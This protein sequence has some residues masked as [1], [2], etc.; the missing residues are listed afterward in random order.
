MY[1]M[2]RLPERLLLSPGISVA[3]G[4][5]FTILMDL[6]HILEVLVEVA[7][8]VL[9]LGRWSAGNFGVGNVEGILQITGRVL[10]RDEEGIEVLRG[11]VSRCSVKMAPRAR[12]RSL[13]YPEA[14]LDVLVGGHLD[15]ASLEEDLSRDS[16]SQRRAVITK[17]RLPLLVSPL[18]PINTNA[19]TYRNSCRILFRG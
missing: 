10:L 12:A 15:E 11:C 5:E 9:G 4:A 13:T 14:S 3:D 2:G 1:G 16:G 7:L 17:Q 8:V 19:M 18:D 6:S